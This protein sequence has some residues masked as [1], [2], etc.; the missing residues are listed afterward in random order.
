[1]HAMAMG[2]CL[3]P[4]LPRTELMESPCCAETGAPNDN[5]GRQSDA[6]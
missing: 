2:R 5:P 6:H 1:V 4:D 3:M